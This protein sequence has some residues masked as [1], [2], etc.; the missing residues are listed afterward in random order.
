MWDFALIPIK[1]NKFHLLHLH[2]VEIAENLGSSL[3]F[4]VTTITLGPLAN[5]IIM[6]FMSSLKF[7]MTCLF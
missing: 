2:T 4:V 6:P 7:F 5:V 3:H 1:F